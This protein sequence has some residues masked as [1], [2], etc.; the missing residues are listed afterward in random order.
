M[1]EVVGGGCEEEGGYRRR[2]ER[3]GKEGKG[4]GRLIYPSLS[5]NGDFIAAP[6]LRPHFPFSPIV[7][8][9]AVR[10]RSSP[11]LFFDSHLIL[12][13]SANQIAP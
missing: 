7:E 9:S 4:K 12:S 11:A 5:H 1:I 8:K 10:S 2:K 13:R 3:K 6:P